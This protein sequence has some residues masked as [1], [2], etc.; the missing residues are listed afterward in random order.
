MTNR[1]KCVECRFPYV[2]KG[3]SDKDWT[4]YECGNPSSEFYK[5]LLNINGEGCKL[6]YISWPGCVHGKRR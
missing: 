3:A 4:A 2:D 5:S 1:I 6:E